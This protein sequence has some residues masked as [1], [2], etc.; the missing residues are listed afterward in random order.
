MN[1]IPEHLWVAFENL[2]E[3]VSAMT[4]GGLQDLGLYPK[5]K[6]KTHLTPLGLILDMTNS[7]GEGFSVLV[8]DTD[9]PK[10]IRDRIEVMGSTL[11]EKKDT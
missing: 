3:V 11:K 5:R 10:V 6:D 4:T 7:K 1:N 9:D 8:M 2:N